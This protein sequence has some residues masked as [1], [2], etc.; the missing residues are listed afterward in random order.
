MEYEF[1]IFCLTIIAIIALA[2][3]DKANARRAL[4][5]VFELSGGVL[6]TLRQLQERIIR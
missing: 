2:N 4:E 6:Q 3:G 5:I 1:T